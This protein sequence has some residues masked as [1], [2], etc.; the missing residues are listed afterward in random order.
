MSFRIIIPVRYT[1]SRLPGKPLE[2]IAGKPMVQHVY[3][4]CM[5]SGAD[6]VV[7]AT[8]NELVRD[9]AEKFG[10]SVCMT[11]E[12]HASGTERLAEAVVAL[13]YE[14][15]EIVVNVQGDEPLIS[16]EVIRQ[17][18]EDL[19]I[20]DNTKVATLCEK[21][22][23]DEDVFNP[24]VVKVVMNKRGFALYFSRAPIPWERENFATEPKKVDGP[25]YRHVGIYAYRVGFLDQYLQWELSPIGSREELEQLR[26]LWNCGRIHISIAK[27][28][29]PPGVDTPEDLERVRAIFAQ[30]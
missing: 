14:A 21:I 4:R 28:S 10:A 6:S 26:V 11:S 15:D 5:E 13:G 8:D 30:G 24:G 23:D 22:T 29:I 7:I 3:E 19:T 1:S 27:D 17:V 18:A 25:F 16:P 20:H 9:A 12:D 2:A